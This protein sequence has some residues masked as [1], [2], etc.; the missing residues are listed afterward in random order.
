MFSGSHIVHE[1]KRSTHSEFQ[2]KHIGTTAMFKKKCTRKEKRNR[3]YDR[4]INTRDN[5]VWGTEAER[6][7]YRKIHGTFILSTEHDTYEDVRNMKL[8]S[9]KIYNF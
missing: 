2:E 8:T 5:R 4:Y 7:E 1:I 6:Y 9:C 3:T